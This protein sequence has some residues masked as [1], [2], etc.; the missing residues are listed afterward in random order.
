MFGFEYSHPEIYKVLVENAAQD[1]LRKESIAMGK[2]LTNDQSFLKP[3]WSEFNRFSEAS[4]WECACLCS[5]INPK[6]EATFQGGFEYVAKSA[7]GPAAEA[8]KFLLLFYKAV[9]RQVDSGRIFA[10]GSRNMVSVR[11]IASWA[12]REGQE[13]PHELRGALGLPVGVA[14]PIV[15][16]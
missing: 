8:G 5:G 1:R 3:D 11:E 13:I 14:E 9:K 2:A 15:V 12:V 10:S 7:E 6:H 16:V 4:L